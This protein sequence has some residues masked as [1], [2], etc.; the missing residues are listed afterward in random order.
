MRQFAKKV[1]RFGPLLVAVGLTATTCYDKWL[2]TPPKDFPVLLQAVINVAA[3][4]VGFLATAKGILI[5]VHE[6]SII[7]RLKEAEQF[8][9]LVNYFIEAVFWC[10]G[11]CLIS[12][13]LLV[14]TFPGSTVWTRILMVAWIGFLGGAGTACF[15]VIYLFSAILR[16]FAK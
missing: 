3:I 6:R 12:A 11:L 15:R 8:L 7:K 9:P 16:S 10:M 14:A 1:E 5:S 2:L 13:C 4:A